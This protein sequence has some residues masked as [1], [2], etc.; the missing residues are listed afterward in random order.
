MEEHSTI[1][2][3]AMFDPQFLQAT[4]ERIPTTIPEIVALVEESLGVIS[5]APNPHRH[6]GQTIIGQDNLDY[7]ANS[8]ELVT[9]AHLIVLDGAALQGKGIIMTAFRIMY[10]QTLEGHQCW[11]CD[12]TEQDYCISSS[13]H[14]SI[15]E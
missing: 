2:R 13:G 7:H 4:F 14:W 1:A 10:L 8:N 12:N 9:R 6:C 5:M 15:H 11:S 3:G